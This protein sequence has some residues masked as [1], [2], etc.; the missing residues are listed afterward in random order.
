MRQNEWSV[1][2][3][4]QNGSNKTIQARGVVAIHTHLGGWSGEAEAVEKGHAK[5]KKNTIEFRGG[6]T[7]SVAGIRRE[8]TGKS[9]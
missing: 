7:C 6:L 4:E 5:T 9:K 1:A 8:T 3:E 2:T